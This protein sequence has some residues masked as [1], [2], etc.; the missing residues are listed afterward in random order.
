MVSAYSKAVGKLMRSSA[1]PCVA[2]KE[3]S[4]EYPRNP[5]A[6]V[7]FFMECR[8]ENKNDVVKILAASD[9]IKEFVFVPATVT[10]AH[11]RE[12]PVELEIIQITMKT[13]KESQDEKQ[14]DLHIDMCATCHIKPCDGKSRFCSSSCHDQFTMHGPIQNQLSRQ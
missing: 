13:P 6:N 2:T 11:F 9:D 5:D 7:L 3:V 1:I 12:A 14:V 4:P 8:R 10:N